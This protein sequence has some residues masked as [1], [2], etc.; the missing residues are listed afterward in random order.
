LTWFNTICQFLLISGATGI[1]IRKSLLCLYLQGFALFFFRSFKSLF[2]TFIN[3]HLLYRG[4]SLWQFCIVFYCTLL[5]NLHHLPHPFINPLS[6]HLKQLQ[7]ILLFY[8]MY[9]YKAHKRI[10]LKSLNHFE[11]NL[12]QMRYRD[13]DSVFYKWISSF[14]RTFCWIACLFLNV[15]FWHFCEEWVGCNCVG[16]FMGLQFYCVF[17]CHYHGVFVT[18]IL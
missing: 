1:L 9:A 13:L 12:Y 2:F 6:L 3:M 4:E 16:S 7:M 14:P 5:S 10:T 8:F 15:R 18:M 11:L 17:L